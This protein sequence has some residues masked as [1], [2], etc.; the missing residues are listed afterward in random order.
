MYTS[1][2]AGPFG[3]YEMPAFPVSVN[4]PGACITELHRAT[5]ISTNEGCAALE[6]Y[7]TVGVNY[8]PL[9]AVDQRPIEGAKSICRDTVDLNHVWTGVSNLTYLH[10]TGRICSA[11]GEWWVTFSTRQR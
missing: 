7:G 6:R 3:T 1:E 5:R 11:C 10:E 9:S 8:I 2:A 4:V